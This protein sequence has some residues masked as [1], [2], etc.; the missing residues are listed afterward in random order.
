MTAVGLQFITTG[1][2]FTLP[3]FNL[4][5]PY[6]EEEPEQVAIEHRTLHSIQDMTAGDEIFSSD[7]AYKA[8]MDERVLKP[9]KSQLACLN[10]MR[11][12]YSQI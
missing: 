1:C 7:K 4:P 2:N 3:G 9:L 11:K 6:G 5:L 8:I 12:A 10:F